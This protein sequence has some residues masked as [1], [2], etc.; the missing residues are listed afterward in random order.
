[1]GV[2]VPRAPV[3]G[4]GHDPFKSLVTGPSFLGNCYLEKKFHKKIRVNPL[5]LNIDKHHQF[6]VIGIR[7]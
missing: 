3:G 7:H 5:P 4:W 6:G 1:M 2:A